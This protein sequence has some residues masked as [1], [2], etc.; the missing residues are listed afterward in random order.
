MLFDD[1]IQ[2]ALSNC[3]SCGL[4]IEVCPCIPLSKI[5]DI[6]PQE[7]SDAVLKYLKEDYF[8][9]ITAE[10]ALAC[11]RCGVC[12]EVC[13][14]GIDVYAL[15][16]ALR[17]KLVAQDRIKMSLA[18]LT[19]SNRLLDSWDI[20]DILVA[21]QLKPWER[22]WIDSTSSSIKKSDRILFLGCHSRRY[23]SAVH[24]LL[25]IFDDVGIDVT[26]VAGGGVCCGARLSGIGKFDQAKE[27]VGKLIS[28]LTQFE[29]KEVFVECP[30]CLYNIQRKLAEYANP[31]FRI[32]HIFD[33][34][35]EKIEHISPKKPMDKKVAFHDPCKLGR[36]SKKY[37]PARKILSAV[38]GLILLE[39]PNN[40]E[41]SLC[42]GGAAWRSNS[43]VAQA[44][45]KT[46]MDSV[47]KTG[48]EVLATA[49][50]FCYQSFS[51]ALVGYTY[52]MR[53]LVEI[54]GD[55]LGIKYENKLER[56][57]GYHGPQRMIEESRDNIEASPYTVEEV[58]Q[59][60]LKV[61]A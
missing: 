60:L 21:V 59:V 42:C 7:I 15:Q 46:A 61:M 53:G 1:T 19:V 13:P 41:K 23:V 48:A 16:E 50:Q 37:E 28:Y 8:S 18:N 51:K 38:D 49:C 14:E 56:Y 26:A 35:A 45:R 34:L 39:I 22:R 2:K 33:S 20:D 5:A 30:M 29:P 54:I 4:C 24:T 27:Q 17:M 40:K 47:Q 55:A 25:D 6:Q 57:N 9:A 32:R 12:L 31:P 11:S 10:R 43:Q 52:R 58:Y 36:M 44:L 3:T